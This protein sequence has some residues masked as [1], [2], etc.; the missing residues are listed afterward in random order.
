MFKSSWKI[1]EQDFLFPNVKRE[2]LIL[3]WG[4]IYYLT[5]ADHPLGDPLGSE[6]VIG[7]HGTAGTGLGFQSLIPYFSTHTRFYFIELPGFGKSYH[8]H[9]SE[10]QTSQEHLNLMV[11]SVI[12][13]MNL[14]RI[15]QARFV[16]HSF[17]CV[18]SIELAYLYPE[19]VQNLTLVSPVGLLPTLDYCAW[20]YGMLFKIGFPYFLNVFQSILKSM[21]KLLFRIIRW[22]PKRQNTGQS[23]IKKILYYLLCYSDRKATGGKIVASFVTCTWRFTN[24][25]NY[26]LLDKL[27]CLSHPI[28]MIYGEQDNLTPSHQGLI[29]QGLHPHIHVEIIP[30]EGHSPIESSAQLITKQIQNTTR[31]QKIHHKLALAVQEII[32]QTDKYYGSIM[33]STTRT[34]FQ[35][36]Y[37]QLLQMYRKCVTN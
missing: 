15:P 28:S 1:F 9:Q 14:L 30:G 7:I 4:K 17:G 20:W 27:L 35:E 13:F 32:L 19:R 6:I 10:L 5:N 24:Y 36:L 25:W 23:K 12:E 22:L 16:A 18:V 29:V 31:V 11:Q 34:R 33:F 37:I 2:C 3:D 21:I 26:P 8:I